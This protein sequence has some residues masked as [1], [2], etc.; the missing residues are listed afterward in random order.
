[1]DCLEPGVRIPRGAL[2]A[3]VKPVHHDK[4][5]AVSSSVR[6]P[7][8]TSVELNFSFS[9]RNIQEPPKF[10]VSES[11]TIAASTP[12]KRTVLA[13]HATVL[14]LLDPAK[15]TTIEP[16]SNT[17]LDAKLMTSEPLNVLIDHESLVPDFFKSAGNKIFEYM[18][19]FCGVNSKLSKPSSDQA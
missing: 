16:P 12:S 9:D 7:L 18:A 3:T 6:E 10:Y 17:F 19:L 5:I 13:S 8:K 11:S 15:Q 4:L 14:L 2:A 1:M